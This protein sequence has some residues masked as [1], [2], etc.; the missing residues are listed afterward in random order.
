VLSD[1]DDCSVLDPQ[2]FGPTSA[3]L[4]ALSHFRCTQFG[5]TC[6]QLDMTSVGPR[7]NCKPDAASPEIEDPADFIDVFRAQASDPRRVAFGAIVGHT[8]IAIELRAPSGSVNPIPALAHSCVWPEGNNVNGADPAVRLTW[9][10]SEFGDRGSV[11]TICNA[12][13]SDAATKIGIGLRRAMGD[14]CVEDDVPLDHCEAVDEV[15]RVETPLPPCGASSASCWEL[16]PDER[17]CPNA[18]HQKLVVHRIGSAPADTYT[19]LRC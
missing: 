8:D 19:L 15:D 9:L 2:I 11:G 5:L 7:T 13:L 6:D 16:V 1:E 4:G 10:A 14:P 18:A 12:D 17:T 3:A